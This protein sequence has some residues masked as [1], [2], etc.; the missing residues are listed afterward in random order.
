[1][2]SKRATLAAIAYHLP[3]GTLTNQ[4]LADEDGGLSAELILDKTGIAERR[5]AAPAE[6]ASDLAVAAAQKLFQDGICAPED[7]DFLILCT[8]S[9]D[10]FLPTTACLVQSRLGLPQHCGAVDLNQ[11]CSGYVYG[12]AF[13]KSLVEAGA[14]TNVLLIT[15]ETY[16][17]FINPRDRTVRTIF[18]DAAAATLVREVVS[19][20][21]LIGPFVFGTDGTGASHLIVPAGGLRKPCTEETS[22][23]TRDRSGSWRSEQNLYM[24]G[25]EIF[26]FTL[27]VVPRTV[28]ALLERSRLTLADIDWFIFHQANR[29]MLEHLRS[30]LKIP[31]EKYV[32]SLGDCGNT[33]SSSIPI[34]L[35]RE[36]MRG[37]IRPRQTLMM[38]GFG[39]GLS[40]AGALLRTT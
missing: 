7:I 5:I 23:E 40:W 6:C 35:K 26:N 30:K 21:E 34:A 19:D 2:G 3:A 22:V 9:P 13:A 33:V 32:I 10:Y 36:W 27:K 1:M 29:F 31:S 8:Q 20:E 16:S 4:Q 11:G 37:A 15:A 24:N 18:G 12:L 25:A 28:Q 17:K 14:A 38:V 39:V